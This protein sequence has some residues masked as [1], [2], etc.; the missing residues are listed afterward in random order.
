MTR[1]AHTSRFL[2]CMRFFNRCQCNRWGKKEI[3]LLDLKPCERIHSKVRNV[4]AT[5]AGQRYEPAT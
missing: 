3:N 4:C 1:V 2:R 5:H